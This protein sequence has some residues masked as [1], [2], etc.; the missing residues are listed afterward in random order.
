MGAFGDERLCAMGTV[1]CTFEVKVGGCEL[2]GFD[3]GGLDGSLM[4]AHIGMMAMCVVQDT[5]RQQR[6]HATDNTPIF[7]PL[8]TNF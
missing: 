3:A 6:I 4:V 7:H 2:E 1:V 5:L 8:T